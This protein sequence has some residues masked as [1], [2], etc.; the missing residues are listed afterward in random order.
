MITL[1]KKN[2]NLFKAIIFNRNSKFVI[3]FWK[4]TFHHLK[5]ALLY[6]TIYHFQTNEQSERT[7]QIVKITLKY[8]LMKNDVIDFITLLSSIQTVMNNSINVFTNVFSNEIFYEFK[9]LKVTNLLNNDVVKM[10]IENDISKIIVEK[11][12]I[13][14]KKK[15]KMS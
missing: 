15:Q 8:F 11:K 9:I 7:N 4:I 14:L 6:I 5:I 1:Q 3:S 12:R 13:M 10:K 2:W